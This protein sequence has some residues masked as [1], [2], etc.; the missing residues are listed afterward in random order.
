MEF[1]AGDTVQLKS[2]GPVM[3]V[4]RIGKD[5]K[6]QEDVV[7]CIWFHNEGKRQ[8]LNRDGFPPVTISKYDPAAAFGVMSVEPFFR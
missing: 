7:F 1:Q 6:T 2:G 5:Q 8:V 4:E 3:T